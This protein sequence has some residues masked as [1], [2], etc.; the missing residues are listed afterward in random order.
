MNSETVFI[1][2]KALTDLEFEKLYL[3]IKIDLDKKKNIKKKKKKMITNEEAQLYLL[4][5]VY[6]KTKK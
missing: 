3:M 1:V 2:A 5:T 4:K 6:S